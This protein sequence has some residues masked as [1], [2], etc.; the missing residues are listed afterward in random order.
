MMLAYAMSRAGAEVTYVTNNVPIFDS[1]FETYQSTYPITKIVGPSFE[2]PHDLSA[3]WVVVIPTGSFD[4]RFYNAALDHAKKWNSRVALLSFETPNWYN[5][6][7]PYPRSPLPTESWR[8]VVALGGLVVTIAQEG[9]APARQFFGADR[10]GR[11]LHFDAWHP[12]IN[13]LAAQSAS[14]QLASGIAAA[15]GRRRIV[16][17]VRTEDQHKGAHDLL[18][19]PANTFDGQ[20]LALVFGRG[21]NEAY[22]A[23]LRRH[24]STAQNFFIELHSQISDEDKFVLLAQARMLLFTSYFEGFGYPPVEAA[25]MGVPTVAYDLPVLRET[26]GEAAL[27]VPPGDT[28]ALAAAIRQTLSDRPV[29]EAIR[30]A[31]TVV[32][33]TATAGDNFLKILG[34]AADFLAPIRGVLAPKT[35]VNR[36]VLA[37]HEPVRS[38]I[39]A[40]GLP[41]SLTE[42]KA[43]ARLGPKGPEVVIG[44]RCAGGL[45]SDRLHFVFAGSKVSEHRLHGIEGVVEEFVCRG[46]IES[47]PEGAATKC[48]LQLHRQ[49]EANAQVRLSVP[50]E[51]DQSLLCLRSLFLPENL[52]CSGPPESAAVILAD[53]AAFGRDPT[54]AM[55]FSEIC[56]TLAAQ[57]TP[58][59]LLL[60][61]PPLLASA[62][63]IP[64]DQEFWPLADAVEV[65]DPQQI[66]AAATAALQANH[67]VIVTQDW[68]ARIGDPSGKAVGPV[69]KSKATAK[70]LASAG[71]NLDDPS[72]NIVV[73]TASQKGVIAKAIEGLPDPLV[74]RRSLARRSRLR[75]ILVMADSPIAEFAASTLQLLKRLEQRLGHTRV[76]L[77]RRLSANNDSTAIYF[78][79]MGCVEVLDEASIAKEMAASGR[80]VGLQLSPAADQASKLMLE[81]LGI[82]QVQVT[83]VTAETDLIRALSTPKDAMG[84]KIAEQIRSLFPQN[85]SN[86]ALGNLLPGSAFVGPISGL[87]QRQE[88]LPM[89][90]T[91][92]VLSFTLPSLG[93]EMS[94]LSGWKMVDVKGAAL[95]KRIGVISFDWQG[96]CPETDV[97]LELLLQDSRPPRETTK[98]ANLLFNVSLNGVDLG[99]VE[100]LGEA[101][102]RYSLIVRPSSWNPLGAQVLLLVQQGDSGSE[103][104]GRQ[105][106]LVS[107]AISP[108]RLPEFDWADFDAKIKT[109]A[110]MLGEQDEGPFAF[111]RKDARAGFARLGRGWTDPEETG[112]SNDK[113]SAVIS[114]EP[115]VQ[116][117]SPAIL[118]FNCNSL[119]AENLSSQ[120]VSLS[121]GQNHLAEMVVTSKPGA[122]YDLALPNGLAEQGIDH[123]LLRFPDVVRQKDLAKGDSN[124]LAGL[125][126]V[127]MELIKTKKRV[128]HFGDAQAKTSPLPAS[129]RLAPGVLRIAGAGAITPGA[130]FHLS[131]TSVFAAAVPC[132]NGGWECC[133]RLKAEHRSASAILLS[134]LDDGAILD[135]S[136]VI[137]SIEV[138]AED[139]FEPDMTADALFLLADPNSAAEEQGNDLRTWVENDKPRLRFAIENIPLQLP[140]VT[141]FGD[142][143]ADRRILNQGWSDFDTDYTW[144]Q[145]MRAELVLG[146]V[147]NRGLCLMDTL[148]GSLIVPGHALQRIGVMIG[149]QKV[150]T[151]AD[152]RGDALW[153]RLA[154][155]VTKSQKAKIAFELSDAVRPDSIGLSIDERQLGVRLHTMVLNKLDPQASLD[156]ASGL[157]NTVEWQGSGEAL[158]EVSGW[159]VRLLSAGSEV[160]MLEIS[161]AGAAPFG[162]S[163]EGSDLVV[164]PVPNTLDGEGDEWQALLVM[165]SGQV[166]AAKQSSEPIQVWL[167]GADGSGLLDFGAR[168]A[169]PAIK[170]N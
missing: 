91:G 123:V 6:Q 119:P 93:H 58:S 74:A 82:P 36:P 96:P 155:A 167:H 28:V 4:D 117:A 59:R 76:I 86:T 169:G 120:R 40:A 79:I 161:G 142:N 163:L 118:S 135:A 3:H 88:P 102:R 168:R 49:S 157:L 127:G 134:L 122:T 162:L 26:V 63:H 1:D 115:P 24:F 37:S 18:A 5:G 109:L 107:L 60:A 104:A 110:P 11:D 101:V 147:L 25:W 126:L 45:E 31:M 19:L 158:D 159:A 68:A 130:R 69:A 121:F 50:V 105:A 133:L 136:A 13:D 138:W 84:G 108:K 131:G 149:S 20:I 39:V 148:A 70:V 2:T 83:S 81:T 111:F 51:I 152:T 62:E 141:H 160:D 143:M 23:A 66:L 9:V 100:L 116:D 137:D 166:Q 144:S 10:E 95:E 164:H 47:L 53:L 170:V 61:R 129:I 57:N 38:L 99:R 21:V 154:F 43:V 65:L 17:F 12:P 97:E 56:E 151:I 55:A 27:F 78:G 106:R 124:G 80:V 90:K 165:S 46:V 67:R 30:T 35:D 15:A 89:I 85:P 132:D 98:L 7:S 87:P 146:G 113:S 140:F 64:L 114:F 48:T 33:D 94:L 156:V 153:R 22:V 52:P 73:L 92:G 41:F 77:P 125:N 32:P 8:R 72:Q 112:V 150:A 103:A 29:G 16:S 145:K 75:L 34:K 44:G 14:V 128:F 54:V 139:L 71:N 42:L